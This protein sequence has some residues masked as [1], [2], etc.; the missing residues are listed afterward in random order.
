MSSVTLNLQLPD[1]LAEQARRL[2]L[3]EPHAVEAWL[4]DEVKR[5]ERWERIDKLR[6]MSGDP[7]T[8]EEIQAEVDIVRSQRRVGN[9]DRR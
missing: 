3:L 1:S 2:G 9:E 6:S 5:R 4:R 8:A 7:M